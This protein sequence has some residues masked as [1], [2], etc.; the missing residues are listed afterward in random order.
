[1][2]P[3]SGSTSTLSPIQDL[4]FRLESVKCLVSMIKSMGLWMNQQLR[5]GD[6]GTPRSSENDNSG[7]SRA[8]FSVEDGNAIDF[9]LQNEANSESF[10]A[11]TLEQRRAYKLE[12]QVFTNDYQSH[13]LN[14]L[15]KNLFT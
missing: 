10:D 12:L 11:A 6:S 2:G 8:T 1:M 14:I 4:T 3:P 13:L 9:E 7:E 5:I 15:Q